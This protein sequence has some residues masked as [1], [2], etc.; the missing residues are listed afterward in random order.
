MVRAQGVVERGARDLVKY[1]WLAE[2]GTVEDWCGRRGLMSK[3]TI[4][5]GAN[6][7]GEARCV[8]AGGIR[9]HRSRNG[10]VR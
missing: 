4:G 10:V 3:G 8:K 6:W 7:S 9:R 5:R 2:Q 1:E